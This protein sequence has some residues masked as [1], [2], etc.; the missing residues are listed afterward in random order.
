[1]SKL[2][3][4]L[5][6]PT[7]TVIS[8]WCNMTWAYF[9]NKKWGFKQQ[10]AGW[11]LPIPKFTCLLSHDLSW[12]PMIVVGRSFIFN[13][14]DGYRSRF[15]HQIV[16]REWITKSV[17]LNKVNKPNEE[18]LLVIQLKSF[19]LVGETLH[20]SYFNHQSPPS[21]LKILLSA[22]SSFPESLGYPSLV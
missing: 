2:G 7:K 6:W 19:D 18:Q 3:V 22:V 17:F 1:M 15:N 11:P 4:E 20:L 12:S 14:W 5:I 13:W 10:T 16:F 9:S 21:F 8:N